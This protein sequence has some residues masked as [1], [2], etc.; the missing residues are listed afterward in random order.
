MEQSESVVFVAKLNHQIIGFVQLYPL[1]SSTR[2]RRLWLLND[3]FVDEL[4]RGKGASKLL[5]AA[6][7]KL[8]IRTNAC[9]MMLETTK[10]NEVSNQL[11]SS[12][13]FVLDKELNFY[14]WTNMD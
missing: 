9:G 5:I 10:K 14:T 2:L 4:H 11:Y 6:A 12:T 7:K 8:C 13:G 1:F 3:L